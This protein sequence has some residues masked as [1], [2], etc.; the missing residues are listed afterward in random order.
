M[1]MSRGYRAWD[2]AEHGQRVPEDLGH[3]SSSTG[4]TEGA[5]SD[6]VAFLSAGLRTP[7]NLNAL[8]D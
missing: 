3:L 1:A 7:R 5:W 2:S 8:S 4:T 6:L